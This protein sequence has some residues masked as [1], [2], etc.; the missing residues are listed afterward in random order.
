M[1]NRPPN[2]A[3]EDLVNE[4]SLSE[5]VHHVRHFRMKPA[6]ETALLSS[7]AERRT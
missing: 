6:T 3:V 2:I 1:N 5:P 4:R 7:S